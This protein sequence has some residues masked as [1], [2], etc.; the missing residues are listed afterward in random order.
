MPKSARNNGC[1]RN[2]P[3]RHMEAT[4]S[5]TTC[6]ECGLAQTQLCKVGVSRPDTVGWTGKLGK[7]S[8]RV[9]KL[10][11]HG[12]VCAMGYQALERNREGAIRH[13]TCIIV[14]TAGEFWESLGDYSL[15]KSWQAW[16]APHIPLPIPLVTCPPIYPIES[17]RAVP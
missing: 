13:Y 7:A 3:S 6:L 12:A 8:N 4:P 15:I 10:H 2:V 16:V 14:E 11:P 1:P 17:F 9:R 5:I